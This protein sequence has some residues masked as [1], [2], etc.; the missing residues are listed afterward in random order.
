MP[1]FSLCG[2]PAGGGDTGPLPDGVR[3][4]ADA[5]SGSTGDFDAGSPNGLSQP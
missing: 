1:V 4:D 2:S 3:A 5:D